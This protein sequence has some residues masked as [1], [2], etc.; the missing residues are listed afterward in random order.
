MKLACGR[1]L[2]LLFLTTVLLDGS[3]ALAQTR[4][5][6]SDQIES[7]GTQGAAGRN[8]W[9][10][11][12]GAYHHRWEVR[13]YG[14]DTGKQTP[15][16]RWW[17]PQARTALEAP[18][19]VDMEPLPSGTHT[20][21]FTDQGWDIYRG[22][23][24]FRSLMHGSMPPSFGGFLPPTATSSLDIEI[25]DLPF[26]RSKL[27]FPNPYS[28]T[29]LSTD[30]LPM[31]EIDNPFNFINNMEKMGKDEYERRFKE[32]QEHLAN[33]KKEGP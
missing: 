16:T 13:D 33:L 32:F 23:C 20:Y 30:P 4:Y 31:P 29:G 7:S 18:W 10:T 8:T 24:A 27:G 12:P 3:A 26:T 11:G 25:C 22:T 9:T 1:F 19:T 17:L 2:T 5:D 21:G 28:P 15:D 14:G 6:L